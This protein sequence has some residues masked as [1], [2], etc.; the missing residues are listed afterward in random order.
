MLWE[1]HGAGRR[2]ARGGVGCSVAEEHG[3]DRLTLVELIEAEKAR[4]SP[5]A[6]ELWEDLDTSL[7][8]SPEEETKLKPHEVALIGRMSGLPEAD[9]HAL[10]VL[11]ELRAGLYQ[12]DYSERRGDPSQ[13]HRNRCVI[14]AA[15]IKDRDERRQGKPA[16]INLHRTV[17][18]ALAR[19]R[20]DL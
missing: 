3:V 7:Y 13:S 20:E 5:E 14:N 6:L 1:A 8:L 4:L 9:Q 10:N 19:L 2:A 15:M 12:S 11:P 17:E 18:Q 16:Q